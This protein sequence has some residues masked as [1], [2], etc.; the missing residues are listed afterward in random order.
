MPADNSQELQIHIVSDA[1]TR[2][3]KDTAGAAGEL[4]QETDKFNGESLPESLRGWDKYKE[5][6]HENGVEALDYREKLH[7]LHLTGRS[8]G[9]SF[10][11][12]ARMGGLLFN[13]MTASAAIGGAA[14]EGV[15][16]HLEKVEEKYRALIER[17]Q[18]VNDI[19]REIITARPTATEEWEKFIGQVARL[20]KEVTDTKFVMDQFTS[21]QKGLDENKARNAFD[22]EKPA[23]ERK[24]ITDEA[25]NTRAALEQRLRNAGNVDEAQQQVNETTAT[26]D[27]LKHQIEKLPEAIREAQANAATAREQAS[28]AFMPEERGRLGDFARE[29]DNLAARF[30]EQLAAAKSGLPGAEKAVVDAETRLEEI[31]ANTVEITRLREQLVEL[32]NKLTIFDDDQRG[33]QHKQAVE[34]VLN[35]PDQSGQSIETMGTAIHATQAQMVSA[36]ERVVNHQASWINI[37]RDLHARLDSQERQIAAL[38]ATGHR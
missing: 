35:T 27:D 14:I 16:S 30:A 17:G 7:L 33:K 6:L 8:L 12:L 10:E 32:G 37:M 11:E 1:D 4:R 20:H 3:F 5:R 34:T 26:R 9:G 21:T 38:Q 23:L 22:F 2:G 24:V 25:A 13:P 29:Q 19:I 31:R 28:H 36:A 15:F 18:K